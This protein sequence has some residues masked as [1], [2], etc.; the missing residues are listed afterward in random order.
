MKDATAGN[1]KRNNRPNSE[2]TSL[3][4]TFV[5]VLIIAL[6]MLISWFSVFILFLERN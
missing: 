5:S 2:E 6:F 3:R 4:G 1:K